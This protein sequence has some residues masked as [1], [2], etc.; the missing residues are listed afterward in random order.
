MSKNIN[1][2][3]NFFNTPKIKENFNLNFAEKNSIQSR[4]SRINNNFS[5]NNNNLNSKNNI[6]KFEFLYNESIFRQQKIRNLSFEKEKN[7]F[8]YFFYFFIFVFIKIFIRIN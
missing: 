4:T 8:F 7:F 2:N 6:N 1:L 5:Y 3:Y